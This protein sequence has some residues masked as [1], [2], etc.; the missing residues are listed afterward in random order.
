MNKFCDYC[1]IELTEDQ[2]QEGEWNV[3][4][5]ECL[6]KIQIERDSSPQSKDEW[7]NKGQK[8]IS[9]LTPST[10]L[11][12][13]YV[14]IL[15]KTVD[16]LSDIERE[17]LEVLAKSMI[18]KF[19]EH[20][21]EGV[22]YTPVEE[23]KMYFGVDLKNNY[24]EANDSFLTF[25]ESYWTLKTFIINMSLNYPKGAHTEP[26]TFYPIRILEQTIASV[27]FPTPGPAYIESENREEMQI[28]L[29]SKFSKNIDID[30][31]MR[32]NPI[33]LR[34]KKQEQERY[35][36]WKTKFSAIVIIALLLFIYFLFF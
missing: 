8:I 25:A 4:S 32:G 28:S 20:A 12:V 18:G 36:E 3:C 7:I 6:M 9:L 11:L 30:E 13:D 17:K 31:F 15:E 10:T 23:I 5:I 29:L 35:I 21:E 26:S 1:G 22:R 27:F 34:D 16:F 24:P 2:I 14:E 19:I 33:L